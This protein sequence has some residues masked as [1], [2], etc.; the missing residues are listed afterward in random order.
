MPAPRRITVVSPQARV[1]VALPLESTLAEL[2]PQLVAMAGAD[3]VEAGVG[4][5]LSRLGE[6]D[7]PGGATVAR[8]GIRDGE[9]L[10]LTPRRQ[11]AAP[12]VFDDVVDA[13]ASA[14]EHRGDRWRPPVA[15]R[16]ALAVAALGF[17]A[18]TATLALAGPPWPWPVLGAGTLALL[19]VIAAGALSRAYADATAGAVLAAAAMPAALVA[20]ATVLPGSPEP[21]LGLAAVTGYAVLAAV[22][23][24]DR[25]AVFAGTAVAA[26]TGCLAVVATLL[27]GTTPVRA[28]AVTVALGMVLT[29]ALPMLALRLGRLPLPRVPSDVAAF[30]ADERPSLGGDVVDDTGVA[31]DVLT[32]LL[33]AFAA[34][35][36]GGATVLLLGDSRWGWALAGTAGLVATLRSRSYAGT[37]QRVVLLVAGL[38]ALAGTG[39]RLAAGV[40]ALR[41]VPLLVAV[42][43]GAVS[44]WY[45]CRV[46]SR[47]P[48]PYW[49][50]LL[51]ITEFLALVS[52]LPLAAAVLDLYARARSLSF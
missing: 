30:R 22:A 31:E 7:L 32:G 13:I 41:P 38:G 8:S 29:A 40:P 34:V 25:L 37:G 20:G 52:L 16:M 2:L 35:L 1:D 49:S 36:A 12:L 18:G 6:A 17:V 4:W 26:G 48:S 50:R 9:V 46:Q 47:D 33:A 27:L 14:A 51:D 39:A 10:Y 5:T 19:L 23:V 3:A 15:R 24:A 44:T 42:L 21:A 45:A 28:A 43:V 11:E